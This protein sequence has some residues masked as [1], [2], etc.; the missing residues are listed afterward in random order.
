LATPIQLLVRLDLRVDLVYVAVRFETRI[1]P[2]N[3]SYG[4]EDGAIKERLSLAVSVVEAL[5]SL[6]IM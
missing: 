3:N 2:P 6:S 5:A 1:V 4:D